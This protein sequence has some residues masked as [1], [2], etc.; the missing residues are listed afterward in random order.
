ME[1]WFGQG[2]GLMMQCC[3]R[4]QQESS[5]RW[6]VCAPPAVSAPGPGAMA[7]P[8]IYFAGPAVF[9]FSISPMAAT[10]ESRPAAS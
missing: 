7:A 8:A 2:Y 3:A 6:P 5:L 1:G 9:S 4:R 10:D